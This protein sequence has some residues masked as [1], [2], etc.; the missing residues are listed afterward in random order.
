MRKALLLTILLSF[1]FGQD[2]NDCS[3]FKWKNNTGVSSENFGLIVDSKEISS[4]NLKSLYTGSNLPT[5]QPFYFSISFEKNSSGTFMRFNF[6]PP[7]G[8]TYYDKQEMEKPWYEYLLGNIS[9]GVAKDVNKVTADSFKQFEFL[10]SH[11]TG[12]VHLFSLAGDKYQQSE[13][14]SKTL[15][16][17]SDEPN[18]AIIIMSKVDDKD[19][20]ITFPLCLDKKDFKNFLK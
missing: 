9:I 19:L 14:F 5:T 10:R 16:D 20:L 4:K 12:D 7:G 11:F 6:L 17:Y 15:I 3:E 2:T 1:A 13:L 8:E 18:S